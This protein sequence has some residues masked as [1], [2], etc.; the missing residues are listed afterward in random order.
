M[1]RLRLL[2]LL[3]LLATLTFASPVAAARS[4]VLVA[5]PSSLDFHTKQVGSDYYKRAKITN[6]SGSDVNLNVTGG[7]PDDFGFG[8]LP[9]STCP[10]LGPEPFPAGTSCYVVVRF[11]PTDF[12][13]G[14]HAVGS[15]IATATDPSTGAVI[16][17]L[18]ITVEG[19][20]AL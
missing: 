14:W 19:T 13:A 12:F 8:L 16:G 4:D 7:L 18:E 5:R 6:V 1:A 2:P 3:A 10:V 9:G 20:G 11:T 15:L 17:S